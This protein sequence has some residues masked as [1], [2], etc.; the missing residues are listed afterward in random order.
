MLILVKKEYKASTST[1][2]SE[3]FCAQ[4]KYWDELKAK[5]YK[6]LKVAVTVV[7]KLVEVCAAVVATC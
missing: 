7:K 2:I 4:E 3:T 6:T 5:K 1:C